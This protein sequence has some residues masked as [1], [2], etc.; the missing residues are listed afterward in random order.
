M[1][2]LLEIE[3]E[4]PESCLKCR[5]YY[6]KRGRFD[7]NAQYICAALDKIIGDHCISFRDG[8][9]SDCPLKPVEDKELGI[10]P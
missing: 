9:N 2:A 5:F 6:F 7:I 1:K 8:R 10:E 3:M 4:L